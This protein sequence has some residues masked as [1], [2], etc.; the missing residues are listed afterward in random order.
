MELSNSLNETLDD[1]VEA[2]SSDSS[3]NTINVQFSTR[4]KCRRGQRSADRRLASREVEK[5]MSVDDAADAKGG[6]FTDRQERSM[7]TEL[8]DRYLDTIVNN[9]LSFHKTV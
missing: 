5:E 3:S 7:Q 6:Y 2:N 4:V 8:L 9:V 1:I